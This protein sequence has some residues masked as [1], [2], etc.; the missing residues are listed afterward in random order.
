MQKTSLVLDAFN[1]FS[2]SSG[3]SRC[4]SL[5]LW[6]PFLSDQKQ[7]LHTKQ[8]FEIGSPVLLALLITACKYVKASATVQVGMNPNCVFEIFLCRHLPSLLYASYTSSWDGVWVGCWLL[9]SI[10]FS[11][12][13]WDSSMFESATDIARWALNFSLIW[14]SFV[15]TWSPSSMLVIFDSNLSFLCGWTS[16]QSCDQ[17]SP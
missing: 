7:L 10:I 5:K 6:L 11:L 16:W 1:F 17:S 2:C 15:I 12:I 13:N 9:I 4:S 3:I 8:L 14:S